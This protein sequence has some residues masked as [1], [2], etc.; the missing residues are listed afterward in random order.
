MDLFACLFT[1]FAS[2]GQGIA[3]RLS[4]QLVNCNKI[5]NK[6]I[7]QHS[8]ATTVSIFPATIDPSWLVY[9][10]FDETVS[11][12]VVTTQQSLY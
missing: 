2:D 7:Q 5:G 6:E 9:I 11:L 1:N 8:V 12:T 10:C 4:N 3:I